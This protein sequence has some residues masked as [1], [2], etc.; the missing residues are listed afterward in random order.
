MI[1]RRKERLLARLRTR[2][3]RAREGLVLVEGRRSARE[4]QAAGRRTHFALV[5]PEARRSAEVA[6]LLDDLVLEPGALHVVDEGTLAGWADTEAPQGILLVVEEPG[7]DLDALP[8]PSRDGGGDRRY[9]VLD[10]VQDPG[11]VGTLL[12]TARAFGLDGVV[13]LDGT[14]DPWN[15]KA[16]RASA[17]AGFHL[18]PV[19]AAWAELRAWLEAREVPLWVAHSPGADPRRERPSLP[20]ALAVG[21][22]GAGP[23]PEALDAARGRLAI[24]MPGGAESLN[25]AVAGAILL[26][27]L[28]LGAGR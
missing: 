16:V 1:S 27:E 19:R 17:G 3:G 6:A 12:R 4:V 15:P 22:E 5:T 26:Y 8:V 24:P 7:G 10:G 28:A 25:A 14:V 11:N 23:R 21:N 9:L 2:K 18:P 20:W 13:A